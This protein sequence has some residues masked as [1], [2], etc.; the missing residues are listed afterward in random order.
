MQETTHEIIR[1]KPKLPVYFDIYRSCNYIV[2]SHWHNHVEIL[3]VLGGSMHLIC[4]EESYMLHKGDLFLVNSGDIHY[5]RSVGDCLALL[6]QVPFEFLNLLLPGFGAVR[7]Q[8]Y[9]SGDT[10]QTDSHFTAMVRHLLCMKDLYEN[11]K[12]GYQFL[13]GSH[14]HEFLYLLYTAYRLPDVPAA[15]EQDLKT[16]NRLKH[17][18]TYV[19][20]HYAEPLSLSGISRY[21]AL[22]PEYF[23]RYFKK[24]MG[25]TFLEYVNMV[26]L[27]HI[28][29]DLLETA[30]SITEIQQRHGF[31]NYKVFNRMFKEVYGCTPS[32]LR[33]R[34]ITD[35]TVPGL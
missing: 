9:F 6:L 32:K 28:Y 15:T 16:L 4:R 18:I 5:T 1:S 33:S 14:L 34:L 26:R 8:E 17:I 7:F 12:D 30:D 21:F 29:S 2:P 11:E 23:C 3:L 35:G 20:E 22:N 31:T 25:F 24:N 27:A 19:E 10:H 13:F